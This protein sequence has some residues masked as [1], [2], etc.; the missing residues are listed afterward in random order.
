MDGAGNVYIADQDASQMLKETPLS[1]GSYTQ[2]TTFSGLGSVK[3]VAVDGSGNVYISSLAYG[4][5]KE[6]LTAGIGV[7]NSTNFTLTVK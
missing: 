5:L 4:L 1:G 3:A 2:S 7:Q 6:T